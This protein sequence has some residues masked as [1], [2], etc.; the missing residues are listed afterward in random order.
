[1]TPAGLEN[2]GRVGVTRRRAKALR[3][4]RRQQ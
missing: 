1:M 2:P 3:E 4:V